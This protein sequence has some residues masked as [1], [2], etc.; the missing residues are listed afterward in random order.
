MNLSRHLLR[1]L[2]MTL[3]HCTGTRSL[4]RRRQNLRNLSASAATEVLESR[5]LLDA[6]LPAL[7]VSDVSVVEG[8]TGQRTASVSVSLNQAS[9]L[10]VTVQ[11]TTR[12][13][14]ARAGLDYQTRFGVLTIPAG[15]T[16]SPLSVVILAD[17]LD[18]PDETIEVVLSVPGNATIARNIGIV[19]IRDDDPMPT[20]SVSDVVVTEGST[21]TVTVSLSSASSLPVTVRYQTIA[22]TAVAGSDFIGAAGVLT[23]PVG[24]LAASVTVRTSSDLVDEPNEAFRLVLSS[25]ANATFG[26]A[27]GIV[28]IMDDDGTQLP[29]FQLSDMAYLGA[30]QLPPGAVGSS[31]FEFG[32]NS[33]AFNPGR[34]SLFMASDLDA[35]L[36]IAEVRIPTQLG[37]NGEI[38]GMPVAP[39]VQPFVNLGGLLRV[40]AGGRSTPPALGY[41]NLRIGGLLVAAGGLTGAMFMGY[42]GAEPEDSTHSHFRTVGLNL[43]ALSASTFTGLVDI[44]RNAGSESGRVRGGYMATVP[45]QWRAWIGANFVTGAAAQNRIQYS[46][47][48]PALFGFNAANPRVSSGAPLV[49]YPFGHAL[50]WSEGPSTGPEPI[51]NG[52]TKIDGVTFVPGTRSVIFLGSNGMSTIGYGVGSRFNDRARPEQGF[53]SQDGNYQYQ[54]WAYDIDDFMSVRNGTLA[55]WDVRPTSVVNFDLPTP[56]V[57]K[58]LGGTAFDAATGRL[59]ISQ[60]LAGPGAT[61]IIHVYQLGRPAPAAAKSARAGSSQSQALTTPVSPASATATTGAYSASTV[62]SDSAIIPASVLRQSSP[63]GNA[64]HKAGRTIVSGAASRKRPPVKISGQLE[65]QAIDIVFESPG[66]VL[67]ASL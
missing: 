7:S 12:D 35:G 42:N 5:C 32:G 19:T 49:N 21:A 57:A 33:L 28:T 23:I 31:T 36:N 39:V 37:V 58:Y 64:R 62:S 30:F 15:R 14:S 11:Y 41:E 43:S 17:T 66:H 40:D 54:I 6:T 22:V 44:R 2:A 51:F 53:H 46:S 34:N 55:A 24:S 38:A 63:T 29:L 18:E 67:A 60:K 26:K 61:P 45:E 3:R 52:T 20:F 1:T 9:S 10:P 25:P 48:G 8:N 50:Q 13:K 27:F 59:Y 47:S 16:S 4:R 65:L 56:D